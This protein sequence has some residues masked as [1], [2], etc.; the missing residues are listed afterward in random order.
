MK[1]RFKQGG[2]SVPCLL[3][4]EEVSMGGIASRDNQDPG[5]INIYTSEQKCL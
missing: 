5:L 4:E 3:E 2:I 1:W